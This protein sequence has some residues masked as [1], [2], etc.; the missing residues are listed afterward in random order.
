[1]FA[2][3][4]GS[5]QLYVDLGDTRARDIV[6]GCMDVMTEAARRRGGAPIRTIGDEVLTAFPSVALAIEAA[7]EMQ[8]RISGTMVVEG[9]PL[10]VRIGFHFGA[11]LLEETDVYGDAVNLAARIAVQ[12]KPGQILTTGATVAAM[13]EAERSLCRQIDLAQV[14]GKWEPVPIFELLWRSDGDSTLM[15]APWTTLRRP[16]GKLVLTEGNQWREVSE[17]HPSLTI[18]RAEENDLVLR[19]AVVS[20]L[21]ARIE[22]R[23]GRFV[24]SDMSANGT[25]VVGPSGTHSFLRRESQEL[26]GSGMLSLGNSQGPH[27]NFNL[28]LSE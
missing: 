3:I 2:D 13:T 5:T 15:L 9:R 20:R 4:S 27:I 11:V 22:Y 7:S 1:M 21:H 18:G 12:A 25:Y 19:L 26:T 6:T 17:A 23:N 8:D 14:K 24:L 28:Y 10:T 16:A